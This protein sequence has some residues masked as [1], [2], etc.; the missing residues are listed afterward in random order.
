MGRSLPQVPTQPRLQL[1]NVILIMVMTKKGGA[2]RG[3]FTRMAVIRNT[4]RM[5]TRLPRIRTDWGIL[6]ERPRRQRRVVKP[7]AQP[8]EGRRQ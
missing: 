1:M 7:G 8:W 2:S 3:T 6:P 5:A 4:N